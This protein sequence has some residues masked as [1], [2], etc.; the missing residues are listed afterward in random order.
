MTTILAP[1]A[2]GS[3]LD[4]VVEAITAGRILEAIRSMR[5]LAELARRADPD[6]VVEALRPVAEGHLD[7]ALAAYL[8]VYA[9]AGV[10]SPAVDQML[11]RQLATGDVVLSQHAAWALSRRRP[12]PSA[13]PHLEQMVDQEGFSRMMAELTLENWLREIPELIWRMNRDRVDD[14]I[15]MTARP[16]PAVFPVRRGTGLRIAQVLMQGRV[17]ADLTAVASGDGGGLITLQVGL[18]RELANHEQVDDVYLVTR[19]IDDESGRFTRPHQPLGDGILTRIDFGGPGYIATADMWGHRMELEEELRRF[20]LD[21]GPFDALHLRFA[22]VGTF[23]AARLGEELGI[24]VFFTLAPDPH[25]VIA[26]AEESGQLSRG[27]F[28]EADRNQHYIFRA[29][30]VDWMLERAER[31]ALLPRPR[32]QEQFRDLMAVDVSRPRF[33]VIPE[34]IDFEQT[35]QAR[36]RIADLRSGVAPPPVIADLEKAITALGSSRSGLPMIMSVGRLHP[37]KGMNRVVKAW[38]ADPEI[39]SRYNLVIVGGNLDEPGREERVTLAEI[40]RA[41]DGTGCEGLVMLG[42]RSHEEVALL[43]AAAAA[44]TPGVVGPAGIYVSGSEKEEFG[45]AIVEALAAGLPVVA[46]QNGGPATYVEDGFT[47]FLADTVDID[48]IRGGIRWADTARHSQ[49]RVDA[50]RKKIK[51]DYSLAAMADGLVKLYR[52]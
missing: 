19:V 36:A 4:L 46:P 16:E 22:D 26:A 18:T 5:E 11:V 25:A 30:L 43:M 44:G 8:A 2:A 33:S 35:E 48:S 23:V 28:A 6:E 50:A 31:L 45:L 15:G 21:H 37:V 38:A 10:A 9:L 32:R 3:G 27:N 51:S 24:P 39:R 7:D 13:L 17:D 20:L 52:A 29:W 42:G 47:G 49:I 34:G 41:L 1:T 12:L 40:A 14:Y